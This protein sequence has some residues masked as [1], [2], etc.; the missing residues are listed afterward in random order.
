LVVRI[1]TKLYLVRHGRAAAGWN[2]D[3]DPG[4]DDLG[5]TQAHDVARALQP[6]GPLGVYSSPLLR[7]RQTSEPLSALW[8]A[9]PVVEP[10][11]AEIPSPEGYALDNRVDW[12]R[13]AMAGTWTAL[14]ESDGER[15]AEYRRSVCRA[16]LEIPDDAVVF[17]HFIAINVVIGE[18]LG[19]DR[20]VMASLDNCS[21]TT[22]TAHNDGTFVLDEI[23][24][25]ADT[26]IR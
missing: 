3:P 8:G 12:L 13:A 19:D 26:L 4:L 1:V 16:L 14:A 5:R 15:Y 18:A 24:R 25:Q 20:L 21:V 22:V 11:V 10:R 2:V 9:A 6:L 23:G 17:S 7:C